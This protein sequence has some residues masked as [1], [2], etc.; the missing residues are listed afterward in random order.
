MVE[1]GVM[2][3]SSR[4]RGWD[5]VQSMSAIKLPPGT[6]DKSAPHVLWD[7]PGKDLMTQTRGLSYTI[8]SP[9]FLDGILYGVDMTGGMVAVDVQT[10]KGLYRRWLDGYNRYNRFLYG[11]AASPTLAGK[12]IYVVDD[13]GYTH[14]I[15]PGPHEHDAAPG[16]VHLLAPEHVRRA[17][18]QAEPAMR[19]DVD[20]VPLG[21]AVQVERHLRFLQ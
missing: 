1:N 9:L 3:N 18:G 12:H 13:A 8:A 21:R 17:G 15:Q 20:E 16:R 11:V 2:Y 7:P 10:Q 14:L 6:S 19:A 5:E 4:F